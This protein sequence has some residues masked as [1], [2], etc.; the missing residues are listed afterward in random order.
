LTRGLLYDLIN[1]LC[2][3]YGWDSSAVFVLGFSQGAAVALDMV[4]GV[5]PPSLRPW[6]VT[7]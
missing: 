3:Q 1:I 6:T 7:P 2:E 5:A 4:C